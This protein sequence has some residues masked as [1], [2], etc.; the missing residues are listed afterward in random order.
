MSDAGRW[1]APGVSEEATS[2]GWRLAWHGFF[3]LLL[4]VATAASLAGDPATAAARTLRLA[5]AAVLGAW[6]WVWQVGPLRGSG[7][8]VRVYLLGATV[9][10]AVLTVVDPEFLILG[11]AVFAPFCLQHLGVAVALAAVVVGG[12]VWQWLTD[13]AGFAWSAVAVPL[14]LAAA[15]LLS[16]GTVQAIV[17]QSRERQR[18]VEQLRATRADLAAA[19]RQ[20]G[21]LAE[22]QRLARE[23]HDTLT[24]GFA[25]VVLLLEAAE[26]SLAAGNPIGAHVHRALRSARDHLADSRRVVWA[27]RPQVLVDR[28]LPDALERLARQVTDQT[29]VDIEVVVAGTVRPL[30]DEVEDT[31]LRVAQEALANVRRHAAASRVTITVS[32]LDDVVMVDVADDGVGFDPDDAAATSGGLGLRGM[33]ERVDA[34]GGTLTVE[35][36]AGDGTIIAAQVPAVAG[37]DRRRVAADRIAP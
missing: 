27:L 13:P 8:A 16:A 2:Q 28:A 10:W 29:A 17:R 37:I 34:V 25:S 26:E 22:R 15:G 7:H 18:L 23:L 19:E 36:A 30:G 1:A 11:L 9:L 35:S 31:L 6:H 12:V 4:I 21:V 5:P 14:L 24:Q 32:Y 20:A 33:R 3:Y